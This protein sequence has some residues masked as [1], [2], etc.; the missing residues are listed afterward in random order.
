MSNHNQDQ[1]STSF[2]LTNNT[3]RTYY[4]L[5]ESMAK[6][7]FDDKSEEAEK[8]ARIL[9]ENP[10]LPL[11]IRARACMVIG[12]GDAPDFLEMAKEGVRIA[13]LGLN[14][15]GGEAGK[16]EKSLVV[17]CK[18]VLKEAEEA[19]AEMEK[20]EDEDDMETVWEADADEEVGQPKEPDAVE[21][22]MPSQEPP[23]K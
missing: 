14:L 22:D 19:A 15:C 11:L 5:D 12:C 1:N 3:I 10:D 18:H 20:E 13:E 2:Y 17:S 4:A 16:R 8:T 6:A 21:S 9:L 7:H 23:K